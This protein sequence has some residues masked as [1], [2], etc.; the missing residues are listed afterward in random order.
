M[1]RVEV[2]APGLLTTVQ[3]LGRPGFEAEGVPR[4]GAADPVSLRA[5]NRLAGNPEGAAALELTLVGG[6]YRFDSPARVG[7][8]GSD[9]DAS[10][11]RGDGRERPVPTWSAIRVGAGDVLRFGSTR[12]GARA[13][14]A[15]SGGIAV[16]RVMGSASTHG[17]SGMGGY[18]GRAL[19]KGDVLETGDTPGVP[20]EF[21]P[22]PLRGIVFRK[23]LRVVPGPQYDWFGA[24][25]ARALAAGEFVLAESSDRTGIRVTGPW[26]AAPPG[27]TMWTEGALP[28]QVQVPPEGG[29][30]ILG[31]DG[32]TTGG[33]PKIA[34]VIAADLPALGQLR[35]R[36]RVRFAF[37]D[38]AEARAAVADLERLTGAAFGGTMRR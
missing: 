1:T 17:P 22:V 38:L 37:V 23:T 8:A 29:G 6:A 26:P 7:V 28:G 21:D 19:R 34:T 30:I 36:D 3:D 10:C 33:Y 16:P 12:D 32:P 15:V 2:L 14:L 35:P 31:V 20:R 4:G 5:A 24:A 11:T 18:R 9:L 25:A 13:Y 27:S